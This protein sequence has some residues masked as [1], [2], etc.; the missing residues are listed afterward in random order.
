MLLNDLRRHVYWS[1]TEDSSSLILSSERRKAKVDQFDLHL[2]INDNVLK[3]DVSV[4]NSF[5]MAIGHSRE[6]L[7]E[8][9]LRLLL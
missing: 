5:R 1:S 4:R 3:F 9:N 7:S 6:E 8:D 2:S